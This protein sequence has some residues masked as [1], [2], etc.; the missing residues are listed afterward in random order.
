MSGTISNGIGSRSA[1]ND[2]KPVGPGNVG[3]LLAKNR[4][5]MLCPDNAGFG[6]APSVQVVTGPAASALAIGWTTSSALITATTSVAMAA[7]RIALLAPAARV[8][9]VGSGVRADVVMS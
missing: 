6:R 5:R 8:W 2:T 9:G 1:K 4:R 3:S 7:R